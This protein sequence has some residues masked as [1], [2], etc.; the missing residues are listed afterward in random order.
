MNRHDVRAPPFPH[1]PPQVDGRSRGHRAA[2]PTVLA[3]VQA[4]RTAR[5][6]WLGWIGA[7]GA[8]ASALALAAF[9]AGLADRGWAEGVATNCWCATVTSRAAPIWLRSWCDPASICSSRREADGLR[10]Q[11][12]SGATPVI[13]NI[14]GDPVEA[15]LVASLSHPGGHLTGVTSLSTELAGSGSSC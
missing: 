8:A 9:R 10:C 13:F 11:K 15:G 14:G 3:R 1:G 4:S 5:I 2:A 6:G 7:A 12:V